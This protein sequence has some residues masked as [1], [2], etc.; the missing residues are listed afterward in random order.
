MSKIIKLACMKREKT[1]NTLR[2]CKRNAT[3]SKAERQRRINARCAKR[4]AFVAL[5]VLLIASR[6]QNKHDSILRISR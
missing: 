3:L 1:D 6:T 4:D 5:D 2:L